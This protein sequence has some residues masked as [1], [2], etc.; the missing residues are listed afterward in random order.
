M[1]L[2]VAHGPAFGFLEWSEEE[3]QEYIEQA[4]DTGGEKLGGYG[5]VADTIETVRFNLESGEPG[6]RFPLFMRISQLEGGWYLAELA[7]L[8]NEI[9]TIRGELID[10]PLERIV[11][12]ERSSEPRRP[13]AEELENL[14]RQFIVAFPNR[15][16]VN[17][18]DFNHHL[19]DTL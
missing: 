19:L 13:A 15:P 3:W 12:A 1:G 6:S 2:D 5:S 14:R 4:E 17:L 10:L 16:D 11:F 18:A 9:V 8:I 7:D